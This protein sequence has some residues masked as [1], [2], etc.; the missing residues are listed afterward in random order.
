MTIRSALFR[1][2]GALLGT[3]S[4][5]V[6]K[7]QPN[8]QFSLTVKLRGHYNPSLN[9]C[10]LVRAAEPFEIV[11]K[12]G[13]TETHLSGQLQ[14]L[15]KQGLQL[16]L[17]VAQ[18][19][20][21]RWV[22]DRLVYKPQLG[23][24]VVQPAIVETSNHSSDNPRLEDREITLSHSGCA[25]LS[26]HAT[27]RQPSSIEEQD[28]VDGQFKM[29]SRTESIPANVKEAFSKITRQPSFAMAN[30]G[31]K[32]QSTDFV[33]DRTLPW[34]RLVLAGVQDDKWFVHYERGGRARSYFVLLLKADSD[35]DV[36][37]VWGCSVASGAKTLEQLRSMVAICQ[38][39]NEGSY[40]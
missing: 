29:V 30:P 34:R 5:T 39:S 13:E 12:S 3:A 7:A 27:V 31:Q 16:D 22:F 19:K 21:D 1:T 40:W 4:L 17:A 9:V 20:A 25:S 10:A 36:H 37:F 33:T 14:H 35:G 26:E 24:P 18:G 28:L 15:E 8:E 11:L 2:I 6:A 23:A 38:F 32:F